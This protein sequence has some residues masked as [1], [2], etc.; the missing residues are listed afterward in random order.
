MSKKTDKYLRL[1]EKLVREKQQKI[2]DVQD[3][4]K[5]NFVD[6]KEVHAFGRI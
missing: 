1:S 2:K 3:Q 6:D 4:W 5:S